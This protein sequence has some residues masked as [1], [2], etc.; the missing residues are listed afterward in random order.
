MNLI[1]KQE[2]N[3]QMIE[4]KI[5]LLLEQRLK[6]LS[7]YWSNQFYSNINFLICLLT[8]FPLFFQLLF[9][10]LKAILSAQ[11]LFLPYG[12]LGDP[13]YASYGWAFGRSQSSSFWFHISRLP[14]DTAR[15]CLNLEPLSLFWGNSTWRKGSY[16]CRCIITF[17]RVIVGVHLHE[18]VSVVVFVTEVII[19]LPAD[20]LFYWVLLLS[21]FI[22]LYWDFLLLL[23]LDLL[24]LVLRKALDLLF[25]GQKSP[26]LE[27]VHVDFRNSIL[28]FKPFSLLID[29][30]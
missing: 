27:L 17:L 28:L 1:A 2:K 12:L 21:L 13:I 5:S 16:L 4:Q 19:Q 26:E 30:D 7:T 23:F 20:H 29:I 18:K 15:A 14:S 9:Q 3:C 6:S 8:H 22:I 11:E 25:G 10:L 24:R